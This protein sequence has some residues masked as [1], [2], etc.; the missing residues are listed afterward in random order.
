M[1]KNGIKGYIAITNYEW[2]DFLKS[3]NIDEANFWTKS[4]N[5][6]SLRYGDLFFFLKK[7]NKK[8]KT[9]R[10]LV[11]YGVFNKKENLTIQSAWET[12][13]QCN[14]VESYHLFKDTLGNVI[15]HKEQEI[16]CI[17]LSDI[18]YFDQP[19]Y[20]STLNIEFAN[21]IQNGKFIYEKDIQKILDSINDKLEYK[22]DLELD[23]NFDIELEEGERVKI[24]T[25]IKKRNA[26]VRKLK[27][28]QFKA[29]HGEIYC[30]SC[31]EGDICT[32]DVHHEQT[33]VSNMKYGHKTK[34]ND[35]RVICAS[36]HRKVHGHHI[37]V[38]ELKA[39]IS[40]KYS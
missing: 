25:E 23:K 16:G 1:H 10:K 11:G 6:T 33:K 35:L 37:T 15:K 18:F 30:E 3:E 9:E 39:I 5:N 32:I 38:D 12:Y 7:N 21:Q 29:L 40:N 14:G 26:R 31:N 19:I 28:A 34:L 24:Y 20:L 36:C 13:K 27:L 4:L 2:F 8:V 22:E 17:L